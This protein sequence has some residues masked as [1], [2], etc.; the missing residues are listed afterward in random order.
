MAKRKKPAGRKGGEGFGRRF[1][2]LVNRLFILVTFGLVALYLI[3][4]STKIVQEEGDRSEVAES[5]SP[6]VPSKPVTVQVLNGCGKAGLA[7]D[8][9]RFLR[10]NACDVVEMGNADH[11]R[12][13][14]TKII[15]RTDNLEAAEWVRRVLGAGD[16]SSAPN[17][18]LL[19]DV[20]LV[21][22]SDCVPFPPRSAAD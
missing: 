10:E 20:T 2:R 11:F 15:A 8:V 1:G 5:A 22:G 18:D 13:E 6:I 19:L 7:L 17:P 9:S 4:L 12:Y 3:P 16:V 14:T 21:V